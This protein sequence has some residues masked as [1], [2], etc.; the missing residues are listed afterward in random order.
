MREADMLGE[1]ILLCETCNIVARGK[2]AAMPRSELAAHLTLLQEHGVPVPVPLRCQALARQ[3][4]DLISDCVDTKDEDTIDKVLEQVAQKVLWVFN[5]PPSDE[6]DELNVTASWIIADAEEDINA[7]QSLGQI[8]AEAGG[9]QMLAY[10][11]DRLSEFTFYFVI[12]SNI[13]F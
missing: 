8:E 3:C 10:A 11:E 1:R 7:K 12:I 6:V 4:D 2:I 9:A 5:A 13:S